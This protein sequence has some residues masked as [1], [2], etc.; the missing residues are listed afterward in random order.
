MG[1]QRP[2][3]NSTMAVALRYRRGAGRGG[4]PWT[5]TAWGLSLGVQAPPPFLPVRQLAFLSGD[6]LSRSQVGKH[7]RN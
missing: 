3:K 1:P 2:G 4:V 6:G 5:A 7:L